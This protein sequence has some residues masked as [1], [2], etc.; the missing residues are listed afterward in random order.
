MQVVIILIVCDMK[1]LEVRTLRESVK[2]RFESGQITLKQ[3]AR[4]LCA[5]GWTNYIDE[6]YT[7]KILGV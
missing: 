6:D 3:A 5:A 4:E 1:G 7:R 2:A